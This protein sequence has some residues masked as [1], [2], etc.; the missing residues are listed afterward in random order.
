MR[1][2]DPVLTRVIGY[3]LLMVIIAIVCWPLTVKAGVVGIYADKGDR[4]TLT[5]EPCTSEVRA[6]IKPQ[7][8]DKFRN[9]T[10]Y[11]GQTKITVKGCYMLY[12][13]DYQMIFE[14]GDIFALPERLFDGSKI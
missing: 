13:G 4:V 8:Q 12:E 9:A 11:I 1:D 14:D 3:T 6:K 5:D 7:W 2:P 10:Y